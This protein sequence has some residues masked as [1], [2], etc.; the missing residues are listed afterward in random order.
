MQHQEFERIAGFYV[1]ADLY[2]DHIEPAYYAFPG[3]K[4]EFICELLFSMAENRVP[5]KDWGWQAN[6][7]IVEL[8]YVGEKCDHID[9]AEE[10]CALIGAEMF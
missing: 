2:Y 5:G 10:L 4:Y 3:D 7:L 6:A 8:P 1:S 9:D